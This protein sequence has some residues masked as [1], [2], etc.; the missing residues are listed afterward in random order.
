MV[1]IN[2]AEL[3]NLVK[4]AYKVKRAVFIWGAVGIGKSSCVKEV[5]TEIAKTNGLDF[6][7]NENIEDGKFGFVD[8]R[9]SQLDPAD[10]RGIPSIVD[11]RTVW[12]V[13]SWLPKNPKGKGILFFDELN[14]APPS[15]QHSAYQL[16]LDRKLG[17]YNLPDGWIIVSAGNRLEDRSNVFDMS[18]ALKNRFI[19]FELDIP[20]IDSWIDW[21]ISK[22]LDSKII[23]YLKFKPQDLFKFDSKIKDNAF[24]TP[25]SWEFVS[26]LIKDEENYK[27]LHNLTAS[28]VGDGV[29]HEFIAFLKL[30]EKIDIDK[31]LA[32]PELIKNIADRVDL[33]YSL[34]GAVAEKVRANKKNV[35]L[36]LAL[37]DYIEAEFFALLLRFIK[38]YAKAELGKN[39][40]NKQAD[41][42][43]K[44]LLGDTDEKN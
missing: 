16:I 20:D 36:A 19:H 7:E 38:K 32:K 31:I 44:Y 40:S 22:E 28:A 11:G 14:L 26:H 10:L 43:G 33:K 23:S 2:H 37:D 34:V 27:T 5:A 29:A 42:F 13:P 6:T 1:K 9:I 8:V 41:K 15:I 35:K 17:D 18:Y 21:A 30:T 4:K 25:R 24:P 12:N 39:M 3:K